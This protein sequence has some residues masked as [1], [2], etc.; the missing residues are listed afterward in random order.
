MLFDKTGTAQ[1]SV[2]RNR[3][4]VIARRNQLSN[5]PQG[6]ELRF[7]NDALTHSSFVGG[8]PGRLRVI[9][10]PRKRGHGA[11]APVTNGWIIRTGN[12][13]ALRDCDHHS[14]GRPC[15]SECTNLYPAISGNIVV[16][17]RRLSVGRLV[18]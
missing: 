17:V 10:A 3:W 4:R 15:P 13:G 5:Q 1:H 11:K 7:E 6:A 8:R 2:L 14:R 16:P 12:Q 9:A 18:H